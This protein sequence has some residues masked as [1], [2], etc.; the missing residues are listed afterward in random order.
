MSHL[1]SRVFGM[2]ERKGHRTTSLEEM[3]ATRLLVMISSGRRFS[4]VAALTLA[5]SSA[6]AQPAGHFEHAEITESSGAT[7]SRK[8]SGIFWTINDSGGFAKVYAFD[9]RGR[10][11]GAWH[12][13]GAGNR[14]W[15]AIAL[16][17]CPRGD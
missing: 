5:T 14:D 2:L 11:K 10:D 17:P 8:Q 7:A 12:L 15:E 13:S 3:E 6:T 9:L 4:L 1:I 16:G